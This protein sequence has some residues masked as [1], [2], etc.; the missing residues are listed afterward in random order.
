[1]SAP[2]PELP[3]MC[4]VSLPPFGLP[5]ISSWKDSRSPPTDPLTQRLER[6]KVSESMMKKCDVHMKLDLLFTLT[7]HIVKLQ[8]R[9]REILLSLNNNVAAVRRENML[10]SDIETAALVSSM[11]KVVSIANDSLKARNVDCMASSICGPTL[12]F[13]DARQLCRSLNVVDNLELW[14]AVALYRMAHGKIT[15]PYMTVIN[16]HT[17]LS[18][19]K[20]WLDSQGGFFVSEREVSELYRLASDE[21][22]SSKSYRDFVVNIIKHLSRTTTW[23]TKEVSD[24]L[25][26]EIKKRVV[27]GEELVE[28]HSDIASGQGNFHKEHWAEIILGALSA[29]GEIDVAADR[30][31]EELEVSASKKI[32]IN[33]DDLDLA[34]GSFSQGA[35]ILNLGS[36]SKLESLRMTCVSITQLGLDVVNLIDLYM[37]E[38]H[39]AAREAIQERRNPCYQEE[40][41]AYYLENHLNTRIEE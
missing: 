2:E 26:V 7:T 22:K 14:H 34:V 24:A 27:H 20:R 3:Q 31:A 29:N 11:E 23:A 19:Y 41:D 33:L 10:L 37:N 30:V 17:N 13:D 28:I 32:R 18:M 36:D 21:V 12:W 8:P 38:G 4:T 35:G 16:C 1:M 15:S 9:V 25:L 39:Y 40:N 5:P 6:D